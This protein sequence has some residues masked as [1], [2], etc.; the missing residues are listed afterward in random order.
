MMDK[1]EGVKIATHSDGRG[2][3][4]A[5][6]WTCVACFCETRDRVTRTDREYFFPF[7]PFF[8]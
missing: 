8:L 4:P 3:A 7:F 1:V 6:S 2:A 5:V